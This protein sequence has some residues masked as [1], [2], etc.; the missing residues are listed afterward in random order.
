M[1]VKALTQS[2]YDKG[3]VNDD[4]QRPTRVLFKDEDQI[5]VYK[6]ETYNGAVHQLVIAELDGTTPF[7]LIELRSD[8]QSNSIYASLVNQLGLSKQL[9]RP[10]LLSPPGCN[11]C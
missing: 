8:E 11:Y 1:V 4:G 3:P 2:F 10:P 9:R 7:E 5:E 6:T